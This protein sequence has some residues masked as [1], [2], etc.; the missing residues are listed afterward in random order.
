MHSQVLEK[1]YE[2]LGKRPVVYRMNPKAMARQQV[3][4]AIS[5]NEYAPEQVGK[6][7]D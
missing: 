4:G 6:Q 7:I 2:Q 3:R 5:Q 1:A